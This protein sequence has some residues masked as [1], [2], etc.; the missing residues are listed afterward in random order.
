[1]VEFCTVRDV[2]AALTPNASASDTETGAKLPDWQIEDAIVE[3]EGTIR[4]YLG[5]RYLIEPVDI[6]EP[7]PDDPTEEWTFKAAPPPIRSWTRDIAAYLVAL[8]YRKNK[9]LTEDDPIRLRYNMVHGFLE[10]VRDREMN[11]PLPPADTDDQGVH[12]ENLYEGKLFTLED[13]GLEQ[14]GSADAQRYWPYR[15]D[16]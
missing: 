13:V 7:N 10:A 11:I 14:A 4:A 9:D 16:V 15:T 12:V 8:T 6:T 1:M 2:R 5:T 3:A